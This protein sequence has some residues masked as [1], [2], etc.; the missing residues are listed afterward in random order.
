M[1]FAFF[2]RL[3]NLHFLIL[4]LKFSDIIFIVFLKPIFELL[5]WF[6]MSNIMKINLILIFLGSVICVFNKICK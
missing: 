3:P 6:E 4:K 2:N 5:I 1:G